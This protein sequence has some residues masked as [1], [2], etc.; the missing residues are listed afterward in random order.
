MILVY[1]V[2]D[3]YAGFNKTVLVDTKILRNLSDE[4]IIE[5]LRG[6]GVN[7][8]T[9]N[10][11][12]NLPATFKGIFFNPLMTDK[13]ITSLAKLYLK[14]KK[15]NMDSTRFEMLLAKN[16]IKK[17]RK[18]GELIDTN[19][20]VAARKTEFFPLPKYAREVFKKIETTSQQAG[21]NIINMLIK[22][23]EMKNSVDKKIRGV[24]RYPKILY[25]ML[26]GAFIV[27]QFFIIP[28]LKQ[29]VE[30][31]GVKD[32]SAWSQYL[33][34][35]SVTAN[36]NRIWFS[37][38]VVFIAWLMYKLLYKTLA[39]IASKIPYIYKIGFYRDHCLFFGLLSTFQDAA[40]TEIDSFINASSVIENGKNREK[41]ILM[42]DHMVMNAASFA[43]AL[44]KFE[45]SKEILEIVEANRGLKDSETYNELKEDFSDQMTERVEAA[46]EY[47]QPTSLIV[48]VI[49]LGLVMGGA[50][51]PVFTMM[52]QI[53]NM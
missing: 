53:G 49:F 8:Q 4:A 34:D 15:V 28:N 23:L 11:A 10:I 50:L 47:I 3:T 40:M 29:L 33:Y 32:I 36:E 38:Q 2:V 39:F 22:I 14:A 35:L 48:V 9:M 13:E 30:S 44:K 21:I 41:M 43:E 26:V 37:I 5:E 17:I 1:D 19:P 31:M 18:V 52:K 7:V 20:N 16:N 25:M 12:L 46:S 24:T 6:Q 51:A 45:Y 27:L 42:I